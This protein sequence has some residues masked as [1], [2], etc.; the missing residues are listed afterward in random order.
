L[1]A[2][3]QQQIQQANELMQ[4]ANQQIEQANQRTHQE[5]QKA[6]KMIQHSLEIYSESIEKMKTLF[7]TFKKNFG[8]NYENQ[9]N[10]Q[11][12][13]STF[14]ENAKFIT[15]HNKKFQAGLVTYFVGI[16]QNSD[17]VSYILY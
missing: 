1:E 10:E 16:N 5:I 3:Y 7:E 17:L 15:E 11:H 9:N 8:R 14:Q 4:K 2:Q 6:N 12:K 13:F